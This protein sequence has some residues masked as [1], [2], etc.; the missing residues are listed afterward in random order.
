[1][2][3]LQWCFADFR[4]DPATACVWRGEQAVALPPKV[5]AV[6][7][8]LVTHPDRLIPKDELL[9]A[10][11]PATAVSDAVVRVAIGT[12]RKALGDTR[13]PSRVIATVPRRGY[14]FLA[15]VTRVAPAAPWALPAALPLAQVPY[16][17]PLLVERE[18]VLQRLHTAW[19]RVCQG[20]RQVVLVTGEAGIGKTAVVEAFA[21]QVRLDSTVWLAYG[22][23]VEHYSAGEAYLPVLEALG[24]LCHA[25]DGGRFVA[26]LRQQAPTWLVQLPWLLTET[27][28]QQW[29]YELQGMTR[30][31]MLREFAEVVETLTA[32]TPLV[33]VLEDLHWSDYATLDLLALLAWRQTPA[34]LLVLG[35]YRPVEAIVQ[36]HPLRTL[37]QE[38]RQHGHSTEVPLALLSPAAVMAYLARRFPRHGFPAALASRLHMHTEGN[39]L[40][41][42][43]LVQALVEQG[44]LAA[45]DDGWAVQGEID[46]AEIGIPETLR[47]FIEH[48]LAYV[49]P[50]AQRVLEVASVAGVVFVTATVAAGMEDDVLAVEVHCEELARRHLMRSVGLV[51]WPDGTVATCYE[52]THALYQQVA[53]ERLG[54][55]H[56]GQL[57]QRLGECLEAAYGPRAKEIAAE[58][59]EHF[60]RGHDLRR[61]VHYLHQAAENVTQRSA[62]REVIHLVTRALVLLRQLPETPERAQQELALHM[63][64]GP[65]LIATQGHAT[66]EVEEIYARARMLCQQVPDSPQ[67]PQTLVG[68][69]LLHIGYGEHQTAQEIGRGLF[70]LAQRLDDPAPLL[71]AHGT[72][73]ITAFYLGDMVASRAH[74]E[75]GIALCDRLKS[76]TLTLNSLFDFAV[77]CRIGAAAAL[78]QLGYPDQ[79]RQRGEEA[80]A[81][82]Q[83]IA[84]PYN[85]CNLLLFLA[86]FYLFRREGHRAQQWVEEALSLAT[87]RGFLLYMALG[88]I[89]QGA[90]LTAQGQAQEGL[91]DIRQ[92]LT[93]CHTLGAKFL[94]PWGLAMLAESYAR[95][96]QPEAGLT[97]L[98]EAKALIGT[99]SEAFYAAEIA[100]LQGELCLRAGAQVP[101]MQPD[102]SPTAAAEHCFQHALE[103]TRSRQAR[104][105]ELRAAMSLARLWQQQGKHAE[106]YELL[107]PIYGWFTEGFDT[108]DLQEAKA[109]LAALT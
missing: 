13:R 42:V 57:H 35:T 56:Q 103:V 45:G 82:T 98:N 88:T 96:G 17:P 34:R 100:R 63:T 74:L 61:A 29:R 72:L 16:A 73:G 11:W 77:V 108:A 105:W 106:A 94:Q 69:W 24:Q 59:A 27:D 40:F 6:L 93:A 9:D 60:E 50:E 47:Q 58:L 5:F 76:S 83:G 21:A 64:L 33:L 84:S 89:V 49:P 44:I 55:G 19:T 86:L 75:H 53:Y 70:R 78:Q 14:R 92:G 51:T 81:L 91:S 46:A 95:L 85:R 62:H 87:A 101:D 109:L 102:T 68:L 79:A 37:A 31:R 1:M 30:E 36:G 4:L 25:P 107:A 32:E 80:L 8:Y 23:C 66:P 48:Q 10:V 28:R 2:I 90:A 97:A 54:S 15:P 7:H 52:F 22:Q 41:L 43:T 12:L 104:W 38:L 99:T 65:A 26:L 20:E 3:S 67:L 18:A 71:H 39:P